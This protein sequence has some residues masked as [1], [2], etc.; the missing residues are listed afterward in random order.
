MTL[1]LTANRLRT[2]NGRSRKDQAHVMSSAHHGGF[3]VER[4]ESRLLLFAT[5]GGVWPHP[6]LVSVSFMPDGTDVAGMPSALFSTMNARWA[7]A[8]WQREILEGIQN[9]AANANL[10]FSIAADDGSPFGSAGGSGTDNNMQGDSNFGDIR[11]GGFN[12]TPYLGLAMLPPPINGDTTAGDFFLNTTA[13]WNIDASYDLTTVAGHEAGHSVGL[14][15][16]AISTA[17]MYSSYTGVKS[18]LTAD[19]IAGIQ[20]VYGARPE[21]SFD[22]GAS[23]DTKGT[24]TVLT[25]YIDANKQVT[26]T[27]L[28]I[29]ATSDIDW[30]KIT[31]PS[32]NSGTMLV[33]VQ[34][35]SLSL[36]AP[37]LT[38]Y[39]GSTLKGTVS[40]GYSSTISISNAIGNGQNWYVKVEAAES[41]VFGTGKYAL[42][43]NMGTAPLPPVNSPNTATAATGSGGNSSPMD[44]AEHDHG[45]GGIAGDDQ[46]GEFATSQ[47]IVTP[48]SEST[49]DVQSGANNESASYEASQFVLVAAT[50]ETASDYVGPWVYSVSNQVADEQSKSIDEL[51]AA[52]L[53]D[54]VLPGFGFAGDLASS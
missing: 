3:R 16:S 52:D 10:N 25:S 17:V 26:L 30:F 51:L 14:D 19:D 47:T 53:L 28:D 6:E 37:K 20:A 1:Q 34:S 48:T 21:D 7:T 35:T 23:N 31:T 41:S 27:G 49:S 5:N 46:S 32:G 2:R 9:F 18:T 43:I 29:T 22:T 40:G 13:T 39:K 12:M 15:H 33:Q 44:H 11:I 54:A 8:T 45:N 36:L 50:T 42:Q 4:L 24:S 38:V